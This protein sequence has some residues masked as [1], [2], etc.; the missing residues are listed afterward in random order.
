M[1]FLNKLSGVAKA[2]SK[3]SELK[4]KK[5]LLLKELGEVVYNGEM[6]RIDNFVEEI[7]V[8]TEEIELLDYQLLHKKM[9]SVEV[10]GDSSE[11]VSEEEILDKEEVTLPEEEKE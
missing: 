8:L 11:E 4:G 1:S 9:S 7:Q 3:L 2:Y 10:K 5:D 6:D